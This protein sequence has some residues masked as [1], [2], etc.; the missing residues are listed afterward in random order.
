[1]ILL[2]LTVFPRRRIKKEKELKIENFYY[3][4]DLY[5]HLK[6]NDLDIFVD[7]EET[8]DSIID[9]IKNCSRIAHFKENSLRTASILI[10]V[11]SLLL[12]CFIVLLFI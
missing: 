4:E 10:V 7:K 6:L 3:H 5:T 9:Q 8:D 11:F 12:V 2:V 1:M